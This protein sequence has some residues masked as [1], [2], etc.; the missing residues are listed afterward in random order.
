[1]L[2]FFLRFCPVQTAVKGNIN[3]FH[4]RCHLLLQG[5]YRIW[6]LNQTPSVPITPPVIITI[7]TTLIRHCTLGGD[8][9]VSLSLFF[10]PRLY[11]WY[12]LS[13]LRRLWI[14]V[15]FYPTNYF[16]FNQ[17]LPSTTT[18]VCSLG[19]LFAGLLDALIFQDCCLHS[20]AVWHGELRA[21]PLLFFLEKTLGY[22]FGKWDGP[23]A[24]CRPA[25][26]SADK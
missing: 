7:L 25:R 22:W 13:T 8:L 19:I 20:S 23:M 6:Y 24:L 4:L 18:Q 2:S 3:Q 10:H 21:K 14:K 1:M 16:K 12:C 26:K 17:L 15:H 5:S 9:F 11:H